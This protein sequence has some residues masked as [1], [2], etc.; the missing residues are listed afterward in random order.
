MAGDHGKEAR[1][2]YYENYIGK[3]TNRQKKRKREIQ[4][5]E[6]ANGI[7]SDF[8]LGYCDLVHDVFGKRCINCGSKE[9][10]TFD[11]HVPITSGGAFLHNAVPLCL[12]C[13][14]A[15]KDRDPAD[16]YDGWKLAE[17]TV[18]LWETRVEFESKFPEWAA[19]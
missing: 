13:N 8:P 14:S 12:A 15:K 18:L 11:H 6:K 4:Q 3:P 10:L 16:H 2:R 9:H 17:I 19:A 5:R 7:V 1:R